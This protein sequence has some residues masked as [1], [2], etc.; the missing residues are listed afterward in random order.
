MDL[1]STQ[2]SGS[3]PVPPEI[4]LCYHCSRFVVHS[5]RTHL[6]MRFWRYVEL[7]NHLTVCRGRPFH[8]GDVHDREDCLTLGSSFC[9]GRDLSLSPPASKE[10]RVEFSP[11]TPL[12]KNTPVSVSV[13]R[14]RPLMDCWPVPR[15][16]WLINLKSSGWQEAD[17]CFDVGGHKCFVLLPLVLKFWGTCDSVLRLSNMPKTFIWDIALWWWK[18]SSCGHHLLRCPVGCLFVTDSSLQ[19]ACLTD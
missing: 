12:S 10:P 11:C 15:P 9:P 13:G 14:V 5:F 16:L 1:S 3:C 8:T 17:G 18:I 6:K 4:V 19:A 7:C 2:S